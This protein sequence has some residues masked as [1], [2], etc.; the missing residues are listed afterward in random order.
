MMTMVAVVAAMMVMAKWK[1]EC[2]Y[3]RVFRAV[4]RFFVFLLRCRIFHFSYLSALFYVF[5]I[6]AAAFASG[7]LLFCRILVFCCLFDPFQNEKKEKRRKK[8]VQFKRTTV[9]SVGERFY[10]LLPK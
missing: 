8:V 9:G 2:V 5:Q 6:L 7:S 10:L 4:T 3:Q 1:R